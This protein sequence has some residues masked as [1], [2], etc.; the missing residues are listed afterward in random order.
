MPRQVML[1]VS[2]DSSL[3]KHSDRQQVR[4]QR[5]LGPA[6]RHHFKDGETEAQRVVDSAE[7]HTENGSKARTRT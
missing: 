6:W 7:G 5:P 3:L 2:V 1:K 4:A